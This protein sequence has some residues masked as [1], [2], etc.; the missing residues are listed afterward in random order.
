MRK[1]AKI[2]VFAGTR[3]VRITLTKLRLVHLRMI[4]FFHC[5]VRECARIAQR[6][7]LFLRFVHIRAQV[8]PISAQFAPPVL[9]LIVELGTPLQVVV[10]R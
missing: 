8:A 3:A 4:E 6:A 2:A 10:H 5:V 1:G 9:G 7:D